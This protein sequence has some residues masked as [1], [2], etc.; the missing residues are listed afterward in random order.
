MAHNGLPYSEDKF[1]HSK[2]LSCSSSS[3]T[4]FAILQIYTY[5]KK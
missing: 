3:D 1:R 5:K 4:K 2:Q